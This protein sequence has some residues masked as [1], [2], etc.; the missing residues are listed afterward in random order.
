MQVGAIL[1]AFDPHTIEYLAQG[2]LPEGA[3]TSAVERGGPFEGIKL[4]TEAV[5]NEVA[6]VCLPSGLG[7]VLQRY[8]DLGV[9]EVAFLPLSPPAQIPDLVRQAA[10]ARP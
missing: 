1:A 3:L 5:V 9:D 7:P 10:A 4:F 8:A 2:V 6:I